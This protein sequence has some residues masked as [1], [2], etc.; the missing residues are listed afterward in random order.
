[1][2]TL[3]D[4]RR[5]E[6]AARFNRVVDHIQA[7][8]AEPLDLETLAGVAC[9]SPCHFHRLFHGWMGETIHDFIVRLRVERAAAQLAYD[10]AK[11]VTEIA[12]DCGFS[13]S[14]TFAR[15]FKAFHGVSASEW[16]NNRKIGQADRKNRK[17]DGPGQTACSDP[18]H[19]PNTAGGTLPGLTLR[20][21]VKH[22]QPMDVAYI[23]HVGS[24]QQNAALF[25]RLFGKLR[26]WAGPRGLL[27]HP[28]R[29]LSVHHD[30]PEMAITAA[31]KLRMDAALAL[32]L[33]LPGPVRVDGEIS[34]QRL[35]GGAY[36][37]TRVRTCSVRWASPSPRT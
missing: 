8:L 3:A 4:S 24:Y 11:S 35:Q 36:A 16:R 37:V 26:G 17:A 6:Y 15:A 10:P 33:T 2:P 29:F 27:A 12:L 14:S 31:H 30:N 5:A 25:E 18:S 13:S 1:M 21:E 9:F 20:V 34:R 32:P 23:R 28:V 22:L 19:E 7:H